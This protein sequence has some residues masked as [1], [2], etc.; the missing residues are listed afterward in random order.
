MICVDGTFYIANSTFEYFPGVTISASKDLANWETVANPL[1]HERL[2]DMRGNPRSGGIWAPCLTYCDGL[3]YL[4][5]TDVKT[6]AREPFKDTPNYITTAPAVT[7]PWSDPVYVNSPGFDASLFHDD[8]GRKYFVNMEW[9]YRKSGSE[10]FTGIL[11]TELDPQTLKPIS[12]THKIFKGTERGL[13]EGPHIY[14]RN[15]Y[16]YL[17]CAEGGT[18]Y[19]HAESVSRAKD[20][21]GPYEQHPNQYLVSSRDAPGAYLQKAGHGSICEGFDGRW[22]T[23]FLCGRPIDRS[24]ACPLGRETAISEVVWKEDWPYLKNGTMVPPEEFEGY[25][26][27]QPRRL[28]EYDFSSKQFQLDFIS[29][30]VAAKHDVA[31]GVLRLYGGD[32]IASL[33]DQN[34]LA[35]RQCD[36]NFEVETALRLPF[37]HFQQMAGLIY[38]YDEENQYFLRVAYDEE[39]NRKTL[40]ILIF[41]KS[42][43]AMPLGD[44][45]IP[46]GDEVHLKVSMNGRYGAFSYSTDGKTYHEIPYRLDAA[47]LSDEYAAPMGF[48]GAF[49]GMS[50]VDMLDKTAYADFL[51]FKYRTL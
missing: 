13:V 3:F 36:F 30:R 32:S 23:A 6:W 48:T 4:V 44:H 10:Q 38:R 7:G 33:H 41:D 12:A 15:G 35:R 27:T 24:M 19:D 25:G 21:W 40:G 29:L 50:C 20:I 51:Y 9:D 2:L 39:K 37:N 17:L 42:R 18:S 1:D 34:L 26:E 14:K 5:Y 46:V 43:F 31:N 16:Y 22:W 49:V 45:E 8:D 11:L 47:K 28:V